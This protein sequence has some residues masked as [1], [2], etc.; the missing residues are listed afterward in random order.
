MAKSQD[1][2]KAAK[3]AGPAADAPTSRIEEILACAG[4]DGRCERTLLAA[5]AALTALALAS[6]LGWLPAPAWFMA[7][8]ATA[9]LTAL[10]L[11]A[12]RRARR[13]A[14]RRERNV[15]E[16]ILEAA[17]A[18][19][20][21]SLPANDPVA[22]AL[23]ILSE[24]QAERVQAAFD[25]AAEERRR[26]ERTLAEAKA[27][28]DEERRRREEDRGAAERRARDAEAEKGAL[29]EKIA[30][31]EAGIAEKAREAERMR[32]EAEVL[33][34]QAEALRRQRVQFFDRLATQ[35]RGHIQILEKLAAGLLPPQGSAAAEDPRA[36]KAREIRARLDRLERLVDEIIELSRLEARAISLVFSDLD[37][38]KLVRLLLS[39]L[40]EAAR[41]KGVQVSSEVPENL[42]PVRTDARLAGKVV[43]ELLS[44]AVRF[45][46][47]G[48]RVVVR[49]ALREE[50]EASARGEG[51]DR[52]R[53][54]VEVADTGPGIAAGD[55]ERIF[56]PFER[57][58]E[59]RFAVVDSAA[60]LGLTLS[61]G[62]ARLLGGDLTV[63][64]AVGTGST[65]RLAVPVKVPAR[66]SA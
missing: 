28:T 6:A 5:G 39:E 63:E 40:E 54:A 31:L 22:R 2:R 21:G 20:P 53:L 8:A 7:P 47:K 65:F 46:P 18:G 35:L 43:R 11:A 13:D 38:S 3:A 62:Y 57:G 51:S 10:A 48:G 33:S 4:R 55:L 15:V 50:G 60:G 26:L 29:L 59:G 58:D 61:R 37:V 24:R 45:T 27:E 16:A 14:E 17:D 56:S 1:L 42:P 30:D 64:S 36:E 19:A 12:R 41:S 34:G 25:R 49:A 23:R 32:S 52:A 9:A 66:V 44:N